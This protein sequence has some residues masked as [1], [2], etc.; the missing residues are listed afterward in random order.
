[1][2]YECD[3]NNCSLGPELCTNRA[4][5]GLKQRQK[6][7]GKYNVG[8]EVLKTADRGY[9]IRANRTFAPNQ[10]IVEYTGEIITQDECESRMRGRYKNAEVCLCILLVPVGKQD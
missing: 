8:V 9:G 3:E 6:K 10:I 1:M 7:G 5:A 4:F 2:L